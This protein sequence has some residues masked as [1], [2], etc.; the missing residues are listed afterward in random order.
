MA[1]MRRRVKNLEH[2][3]LNIIWLTRSLKVP[4]D[5]PLKNSLTRQIPPYR[6]ND[7]TINF[8]NKDIN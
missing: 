6:T 4:K 1:L 7:A 2:Q 8:I 3:S 5:I